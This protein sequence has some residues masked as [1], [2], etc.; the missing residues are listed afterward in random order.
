MPETYEF[1]GNTFTKDQVTSYAKA[2]GVDFDEYVKG[3]TLMDDD[4]GKSTAGASA[5]D[6]NATADNSASKQED[7]SSVSTEDKKPEVVVPT[8]KPSDLTGDLDDV[9][10]HLNDILKV[11]GYYAEASTNLVGLESVSILKLGTDDEVVHTIPL[12]GEDAYS[13]VTSFELKSLEDLSALANDF[14]IESEGKGVNKD[15]AYQARFMKS[16][17][18]TAQTVGNEVVVPGIQLVARGDVGIQGNADIQDDNAVTDD[19]KPATLDQAFNITE[20]IQNIA[21]D[22]LADPINAITEELG[23]NA[24]KGLRSVG[25]LEGNVSTWSEEN[26]EALNSIIYKRVIERVGERVQLQP[27]S[28]DQEEEPTGILDMLAKSDFGK[29]VYKILEKASLTYTNV[30]SRESFDAI[31]VRSEK[32]GAVESKR[33][34]KFA[35]NNYLKKEKYF[36]DLGYPNGQATVEFL[37]HNRKVQFSRLT[38]NEKAKQ[39]LEE[40]TD[41]LQQN[42]I[43]L[44][45]FPFKSQEL[46]NELDRMQLEL[47]SNIEKIN[48]LGG[49]AFTPDGFWNTSN[50][51]SEDKKEELNNTQRESQEDIQQVLAE[52]K[53]ND[54]E[55]IVTNPQSLIKA[56]YTNTVS[57]LQ[58]I[59]HLGSDLKV[60][61]P[62]QSLKE[63]KSRFAKD[64]MGNGGPTTLG[65]TV[66]E[67][68]A[69]ASASGGGGFVPSPTSINMVN[70]LF[71]VGVENMDDE[72]FIKEYLNNNNAEARGFKWVR[73]STGDYVRDYGTY[74]DLFENGIRKSKLEGLFDEGYMKGLI[75][76]NNY[77][78]YSIWLDSK[79]STEA[80]AKGYYDLAY[81]QKD[82]A[83]IIKRE[84]IAEKMGLYEDG[85]PF[86]GFM[87]DRA[88]GAMEVWDA[89]AIAID[90]QWMG[91]DRDLAEFEQN[92]ARY[93]ISQIQKTVGL[94]NNSEFVQNNPIYRV[95]F[96]K[97]QL[98]NFEMS[99]GEM[100]NTAIGSFV[101]TFLE[102]AA[103]ELISGGMATPM[104]VGTKA[105]KILQFAGKLTQRALWEEAKFGLGSAGYVY[106]TGDF[107]PGSGA[108]FSV[109]GMGVGGVMK[110]ARALGVTSRVTRHPLTQKF[111]LNGISGAVTMDA[112]EII[113]ASFDD[114][115]NN[116]DF[117]STWNDMYGDMDEATKRVLSNTLMFMSYG[118]T[119][120]GGN[121]RKGN[122][123]D[124]LT[125]DFAFTESRLRLARKN[126][127]NSSGAIL[128]KYKP[129]GVDGKPP[130]Y[131][132]KKIKRADGTEME[133]LD[134]DAWQKSLMDT[135]LERAQAGD[136]DAQFDLAKFQSNAQFMKGINTRVDMFLK[137]SN[138]DPW[139]RDSDGKIKTRKDVNGKDV[140]VVKEK[141]EQNI[142]KALFD[143]VNSMLRGI[144][145]DGNY[146][147]VVVEYVNSEIDPSV[148]ELFDKGSSG[149]DLG[150]SAEFSGKNGEY[151]IL[152]DI[153]K[154]EPGKAQHEI[155][156]LLKSE[157][158]RKN[159]KAETNFN[160][161][162]MNQLLKLE[163]S[164]IENTKTGGSVT[165]GEIKKLID[166]HPSYKD[167][168]ESQKGEELFAYLVEYLAD[169]QVYA[170]NPVLAGSILSRTQ[171]W[172]RQTA[173]SMGIATKDLK[174][175]TVEDIVKVLGDFGVEG[176][177]NRV[178]NLTLEALSKL[179][180]MSVMELTM[181]GMRVKKAG[182]VLS[183]M[184]PNIKASAD[185][186]KVNE[187]IYRG[188]LANKAKAVEQDPTLEGMPLKDFVTQNQKNELIMN[189]M[190]KVYAVVAKYEAGLPRKL[191]SENREMLQ[192]E[193]MMELVQYANRWDPAKNDSFGAYINGFLPKQVQNGL[194]RM[195][196]LIPDPNNKGKFIFKEENVSFDEFDNLDQMDVDVANND[197]A[198]E[199]D[200]FEQKG[201][202]N[203][204]RAID[205][206]GGEKNNEAFSIKIKDIL[207]NPDFDIPTNYK[208]V[209]PEAN[210]I[211]EMAG[212]NPAK[213]Q[214]ADGSI[215]VN[216]TA[217]KGLKKFK[218]DGTI[219]GEVKTAIDYIE[220]LNSRDANNVLENKLWEILP[221]GTDLSGKTTGVQNKLL[222]LLYDKGDR[223]NMKD[224]ND[225]AGIFLQTKK[226]LSAS[227]FLDIVKKNPDIIP[228]LLYQANKAVT[229]SALRA[230]IDG[231]IG[232]LSQNILEIQSGA[233]DRLASNILDGLGRRDY[234]GITQETL[235]TALKGYISD[236]NKESYENIPNEILVDAILDGRLKSY[237]VV[238]TGEGFVKRV[239]RSIPF[240]S[241][242]K[243]FN[244]KTI[245][246]EKRKRLK[247]EYAEGFLMKLISEFLPSEIIDLKSSSGGQEGTFLP[248]FFKLISESRGVGNKHGEIGIEIQ[249][250]LKNTKGLEELR[251][252]DPEL[253]RAWEGF[254]EVSDKFEPANSQKMGEF[255]VGKIKKI[256]EK[257]LTREQKIAEIEKIVDLD[258]LDAARKFDYAM[259]MTIQSY[260][261]AAGPVGSKS[262]ENAAAY[263]WQ[264]YKMNTNAVMS[265]R[266]LAAFTSFYIVDGPQT[267][268]KWKGE[269]NRDSAANAA[270][271]FELVFRGEYNPETA[272][273]NQRGYVQ[274]LM[275]KGPLDQMDKWL[276]VNSV[277]GDQKFFVLD[278]LGISTGG[279]FG[280][281]E[282]SI[283]DF[284]TGQGISYRQK[285][286]VE[287][288][289][290]YV[291]TLESNG[292]YAKAGALLDYISNAVLTGTEASHKQFDVAMENRINYEELSKSNRNKAIDG[293]TEVM[294]G[295][296]SASANLFEGASNID[297]INALK[298]LHKARSISSEIAYDMQNPQIR[299]DYK[300]IFD[301]DKNLKRKWEGD[302]ENYLKD[303]LTEECSISDFDDN[304]AYTKSLIQYRLE[305]DG[306]F[307]TLTP[308]EFNYRK[309]DIEA[310]PGFKE[311]NPEGFNY[312]Q[313]NEVIEVGHGPAYKRFIADYERLGP[314]NSFIMTARAPGSREAIWGYLKSKG[315]EI[316]FENVITTEGTEYVGGKYDG[317]NK[318][319]IEILGFYTGMYQ[320]KRYNK[321]N[322][323]DDHNNNVQSV[324]FFAEQ[325]GIDGQI[326]RTTM[327]NDMGLEMNNFIS[328]A[329]MVDSRKTEGLTPTEYVAPEDGKDLGR[330]KGVWKLL[331]RNS[332]KDWMGFMY[333][334]A[335]KDPAKRKEFFA[336]IDKHVS[337]EYF[338]AQKDLDTERL[339]IM[340]DYKALK[341]QFS[342]G[343]N[344]KVASTLRNKSTVQM[345][346]IGGKKKFHTRETALR[347]FLWEQSGHFDALKGVD[348]D[349]NKVDKVDIQNGITLQELNQFLEYVKG[350]VNLNA[351][352][353]QMME[354]TK[355]DGWSK[356][357]EYWRSGSI[358]LDM[359][360]VINTV[361]REKYFTNWR[362]NV[363][364]MFNE[365]VMSKIEAWKGNNFRFYMDQSIRAQ[366]LGTNVLDPNKGI[367]ERNFDKF[368]QNS[369]A[370][371]M[372]YN[373]KSAFLQTISSINFAIDGFQA[374]GGEYIVDGKVINIE[375]TSTNFNNFTRA[376]TAFLTPGN[377]KTG[378]KGYWGTFVDIWNSS[379]LQQRRTGN[380]LN[381]E[382]QELTQRAQ[383]GGA[384]AVIS[385]LLEKGYDMTSYADSF[386]IATGGASYAVNVKRHLRKTRPDLTE[387]EISQIAT[388]AM[389]EA[390]QSSQQSFNPFFTG[391]EQRS[392][393]GKAMNQFNNTNLQYFRKSTQA[394]NDMLAADFKTASGR[395]MFL[396]NVK[397]LS[398]YTAAQGLIFNYLQ[399]ALFNL[400]DT[401]E[402]GV[403]ALEKTMDGMLNGLG[404]VGRIITT[405]KGFTKEMLKNFEG[406]R[407]DSDAAWKLLDV[408][409]S[410]S[411]DFYK[412]RSSMW[413]IDSKAERAKM[414][415][416]PAYDIENPGI[417]ATTRMIEGISKLPVDR[418]RRKYENLV[419]AYQSQDDYLKLIQ[420]LIGYSES[421]VDPQG[422]ADQKEIDK[423]IY[424]KRSKGKSVIGGNPSIRAKVK[425]AKP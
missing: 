99:L 66:I 316:P 136:K 189:N 245:L 48:K 312:D 143:P 263:V 374:L 283:Y 419:N 86:N 157:Y 279:K 112:T 195:G 139:V 278:K 272:R 310:M 260:L 350:D 421:Q 211:Y 301:S 361:K 100:T 5:Q 132:T 141:F 415:D 170:E 334:L 254:L 273:A 247:R 331:S 185:I 161:S 289:A 399:S 251:K 423:L 305:K 309:E 152:F 315:Y 276:G 240:T 202:D 298:N 308:E 264:H 262:R 104:L 307:L 138:L 58:Y 13:D 124:Q 200:V 351:Y 255:N 378:A 205:I 295:D 64:P 357:G 382:A 89:A 284:S 347:M 27:Y 117:A 93:K 116:K 395:K 119:S 321:V 330:G 270:E 383:K 412:I 268:L 390:A 108:L 344:G 250:T 163:L 223:V 113:H 385:Y 190:G 22:V 285:L 235:I 121:A 159:P 232:D 236:P 219:T 375:K 297:Y 105:P 356:P 19:S 413:A 11:D 380:E 227:E 87:M 147:D 135:M 165:L 271:K 106:G 43:N 203:L 40:S 405:S 280:S 184:D 409:P 63:L 122:L 38:D 201:D 176:R 197:F 29:G 387:R 131:P 144:S 365:D 81:V 335:P 69:Q 229:N 282:G 384:K 77:D 137:F 338:R 220:S 92:T 3:F 328:E 128:D 373:T 246:P 20:A 39:K 120:Y 267:S 196:L 249:E 343:E 198:I 88:Q 224:S 406:G 234:E 175:T 414:A 130:K 339:N 290:N 73:T 389:F 296:R 381:I 59:D 134:L 192:S 359:M 199:S 37:D 238:K 4:A 53:E 6:A 306:E 244:A 9:T 23:P 226:N 188:V 65:T 364:A 237:E 50:G 303:Q 322:F 391:G 302:F 78:E 33:Q 145:G 209:I 424:G 206:I 204:I 191:S 181:D 294:G 407:I 7:G 243:D 103:M 352:G 94:Y 178:S 329:A 102:M 386:A 231:T 225:K 151:K 218:Q 252:R 1:E 261:D 167:K 109:T 24:L 49:Q 230:E 82:P 32:N 266:A 46:N 401:D 291:R 348:K 265:D 422:I 168:S 241:N 333:S 337:K 44:K 216:V 217:L 98:E 164:G 80:K 213:I 97:A 388:D 62:P 47:R 340:Q 15:N 51:L 171:S 179:G 314:E 8:I 346:S 222:K 158:V 146:K 79:L 417:E 57:E 355:G 379:Q 149:K 101:P 392:G 67:S 172:I 28:L 34:I 256:I 55:F 26:R 36:K 320:G 248:D 68:A 319:G 286:N 281:Y 353:N 31:L 317:E 142:Q 10:K 370:A 21:G 85:I 342:T 52:M 60:V 400:E 242:L 402:A 327:E 311:A 269:H 194:I 345:Y 372:Y 61:S 156:H 369:A 84:D 360:D 397:K 150:N 416:L 404:M 287:A 118:V 324:K 166:N 115:M 323:T 72:E 35:R 30:P 420:Y 214:A 318:K 300:K 180:K 394:V 332:T 259:T 376:G 299:R 129:D 45:R 367:I 371:I 160:K 215:A 358:G 183:E 169:P 127:A 208:G 153:A 304:L 239:K 111:M 377:S 110:G 354:M 275:D 292:N 221:E 173:K 14:L 155:F 366:G 398:Y 336:Y 162:L 56:F 17:D 418:L 363:N 408:V 228:A 114:W 75:G 96:S 16:I 148:R 396:Q 70:K 233:S 253:A 212:V 174:L 54:P 277:Y 288:A 341:N 186:V 125:Y 83:L 425:I 2:E 293:F 410:L 258:V 133:V 12:Y 140:R 95:D 25:G 349:G 90:V 91:K 403:K 107:Q 123:K 76:E 411:S 42:I 368:T 393:V 74:N 313:F 71:G 182:E 210:I 257:D 207:N 193:I 41:I 362:E 326:Y 325:L 274:T 154:Y 126:L 177:N 18:M 187:S